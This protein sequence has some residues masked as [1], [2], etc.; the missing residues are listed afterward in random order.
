MNHILHLMHTDLHIF[1]IRVLTYILDC[2]ITFFLF[3][4][5]GELQFESDFKEILFWPC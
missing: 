2:L 5:H 1:V 3:D 4:F